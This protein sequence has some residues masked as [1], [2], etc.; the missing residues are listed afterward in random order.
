MKKFRVVFQPSGRSGEILEGKTILEASR[1][2]GVGI[3]SVCGGE[4]TC[5]KCKVKELKSELK[6][7]TLPN[8]QKYGK[9]PLFLI[10]LRD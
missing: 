8:F 9:C 10:S 4:K 6:S 3:E 7:G 2:L 1:E 5:G